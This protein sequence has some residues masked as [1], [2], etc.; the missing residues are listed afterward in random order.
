MATLLTTGTILGMIAKIKDLRSH[1][2]KKTDL[3]DPKKQAKWFERVREAHQTETAEDYVE[4]IADLI[5]ANGEARVV[6][7]SERFGVSHAT[8]NK[9]L[10]R[11]KREG[12]VTSQPYRS[13][14]L[15]KKGQDMAEYCKQRHIIVL[16]FL[17]AL[18]VSEKIA[19]MDAE[20]VEHHVSKETLEAF[21]KFTRR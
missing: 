21:R 14:F 4:L 19:E 16:E 7:L 3:A 5:N 9:I 20:G 10:A 12:L 13:L 17:K 15:T 8:V 1:P 18:G 2:L 11:L 6:D